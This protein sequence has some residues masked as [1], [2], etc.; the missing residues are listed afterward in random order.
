MAYCTWQDVS[1]KMQEIEISADSNP[2]I[3]EVNGFIDEVSADMDVRMQSVGIDVPVTLADK[4]LVIRPIAVNGSKAEVLRSV[5]MY[6]EAKAVQGL[7][8]DA[9]NRI[10]DNPTIIQAEETVSQAPGFYQ[11]PATPIIDRFERGVKQW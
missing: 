11:P 3:T 2:N 5:G 4:L 1:A 6:E 8:E 10:V 9:M 7:Y